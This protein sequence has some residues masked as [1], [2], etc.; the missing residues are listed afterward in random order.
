MAKRH[1][2]PMRTTNFATKAVS[3]GI[4]FERVNANGVRV[5]LF[6]GEDG[7]R[8]H[9]GDCTLEDAQARCDRFNEIETLS[10]P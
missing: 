4:Y 5:E 1:Y 10:T 7:Y 2:Y 9:A 6:R 3:F 8:C